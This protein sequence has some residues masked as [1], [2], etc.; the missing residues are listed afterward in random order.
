M[1]ELPLN[2]RIG[3]LSEIKNL[4]KHLEKGCVSGIP[5][6]AETENERLFKSKIKVAKAVST[7]L[8]YV[9]NSRISNVNRGKVVFNSPLPLQK[10]SSG[11]RLEKVCIFLK[12]KRIPEKT[13]IIL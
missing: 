8:F 10:S 2:K 4:R 11:G 9:Y 3:L 12:M 1:K 13:E 7:V 6:G 5:T